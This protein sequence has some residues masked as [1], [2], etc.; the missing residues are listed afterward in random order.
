[1]SKRAKISF[2]CVLFI[3]LILLVCSF[4]VSKK[5]VPKFE[6]NAFLMDTYVAETIYGADTSDSL[7]YIKELDSKVSS[8]NENSEIYKLNTGEDVVLS[9]DTIKLLT[10]GKQYAAESKSLFDITL[11]PITSLWGIGT[12]NAKVPTDDEILEALKKV[13]ADNIEIIGNK[14]TLKNNAAIDLGGLAK[15][16]ACDKAYEI[17]KQ[18][19]N[20]SGAVLSFGSS[21]LL[22]GESPNGNYNIAL[23]NPDDASKSVGTLSL[24]KCFISTS[25]GYERYFDANGTRYSHIFDTKTGKPCNSKYKSVTIISDNGALGDY[26]STAIYVGGTPSLSLIP[27]NCYYVLID[28]ENTIHISKELSGKFSLIDTSCEVIYE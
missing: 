7:N 18:N 20:I 12:D 19:E 3:A 1:M 14:V 28:N 4:F 9:E 11:F 25:G 17:Y 10:I 23:R 21:I 22:Y 15:G 27:D 5:P 24:N 6:H 2:F 13:G 16:Y 26:L 8:Y